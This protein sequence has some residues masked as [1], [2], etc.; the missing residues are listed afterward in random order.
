M[1][2]Q[3]QPDDTLPIGAKGIILCSKGNA[4][5]TIIVPN[6]HKDEVYQEQNIVLLYA[7]KF[8]CL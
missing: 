3:G 2:W 5:N 7:Q 8:S 1:L 4:L 6:I